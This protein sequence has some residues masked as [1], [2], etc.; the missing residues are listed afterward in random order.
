ML[1]NM[2]GFIN[3]T[4][5]SLSVWCDMNNLLAIISLS[6][7]SLLAELLDYYYPIK[8]S[9]LDPQTLFVFEK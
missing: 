6:H 1:S 7:L 4:W 8:P 3:S 9:V 2:L 5:F